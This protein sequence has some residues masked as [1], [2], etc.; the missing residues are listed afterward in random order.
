[1]SDNIYTPPKAEPLPTGYNAKEP[2]FYAVA[3]NKCMVLFFV[4]V[5]MYMVYWMYKNWSQ[6]KAATGESL[7]PVMR[8][9]FS[10]FYTHSLF[11]AVQTKLEQDGRKVDWE[12]K[13]LATGLVIL[14]VLSNLLSIVGNRLLHT[15]LMD[16]VSFVLLIPIGMYLLKAQKVI[17]IACGDEQGASNSRF[18]AANVVWLLL[19]GLF[20]LLIV[21]GLVMDPSAGQV[22]GAAD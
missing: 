6:Y 8:G 13:A 21:I 11:D 5:G 16:T 4:T 20:W 7:M 10:V 22:P 9:I 14:V 12:P 15:N 3:Q 17:N 1:M 2:H 18:T 19:G